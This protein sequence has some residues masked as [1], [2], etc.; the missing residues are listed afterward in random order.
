MVLALA[1]ARGPRCA[2]LAMKSTN[3]AL[4][5]AR[6]SLLCGALLESCVLRSGIIFRFLPPRY[7][8]LSC[9]LVILLSL[10]LI[11]TDLFGTADQIFHGLPRVVRRG[12]ALP[13]NEVLAR[14]LLPPRPQRVLVSQDGASHPHISASIILHLCTHPHPP[15]PG[16]KSDPDGPQGS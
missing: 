8:G 1:A 15:A 12:I 3:D 4:A 6:K 13:S 11:R 16:A 2:M 9:R 5:C 7:R 10:P 14:A